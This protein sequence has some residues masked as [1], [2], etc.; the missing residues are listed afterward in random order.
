[1]S[2]GTNRNSGGTGVLLSFCIT[3][4]ISSFLIFQVQPLI[5][6][7]ILPW[8]GGTPGV[9][10]TCMLFFQVVLFAGYAYAHFLIAKLPI[11]AQFLVHMALLVGGLSLLPI[12]PNPAWAPQGNQNPT[13]RILGLLAGSVGLPYFL[14]SSTGPLLQAWFSRRTG[15]G[16]PYWLYAL[17][18][19]GSLAGLITYPFFFEPLLPV[20]AQV[21]LWSYSFAGF[22]VFCAGCAVLASQRRDALSADPAAMGVGTEAGLAPPVA[23]ALPIRFAAAAPSSMDRFLWFFLAASASTLLLATTNQVC[24]DIAVIPF[25]WVLPLTLYLLSFILCFGPRWCYPR[26]LFLLLFILSLAGMVRMMYIGT[27]AS[28]IAQVLIYFVGLFVCCMVCHGEM[29][30]LKPPPAYLTSFYLWSS[31]GGAAGGILVGLIAPHVFNR[32]IELHIGLGACCL[33]VLLAYYRGEVS[34][35]GGELVRQPGSTGVPGQSTVVDQI[36]RWAFVVLVAAGLGLIIL[37][38]EDASSKVDGEIAR[39]RSFYGVLRVNVEDE[40]YP[41]LKNYTLVNGRIL[42]GLQ[43]DAKE[44]RRIPTTYYGPTTGIG[45]LMEHYP[46]VKNRSV[47]LVGL[48]AG[49][50]AAYGEAGDRFRFYEINPDVDRVLHLFEGLSRRSSGVSG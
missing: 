5:S 21:R 35:F 16:N 14:L 36:Q 30:Q 50:M 15:H 3:I 18:N 40:E 9:W 20:D 25:L 22:A 12:S 44:K 49:T 8:F 2:V 38:W 48:G 19:I 11:R 26:P 34:P 47:G 28:L 31:A 45:L 46:K 43:F 6:K 29:V 42:H 27:N 37:L 23:E 32:Y 1:M 17:S 24:L 7:Y 39:S 10:T 4:L 13:I 33:S 41:S